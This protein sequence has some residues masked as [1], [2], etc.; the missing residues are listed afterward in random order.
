MWPSVPP[1]HILFSLHCIESKGRVVVTEYKMHG[2]M[3]LEVQHLTS[4]CNST[5]SYLVTDKNEFTEA[6]I[7]SGDPL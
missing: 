7:L 5:L 3:S 2:L 4:D 6:H 1:I